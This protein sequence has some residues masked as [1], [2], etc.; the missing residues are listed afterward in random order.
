MEQ[1]KLAQKTLLYKLLIVN[2]TNCSTKI[3]LAGRFEKVLDHS[4]GY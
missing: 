3:E 1:I 2:L 4:T